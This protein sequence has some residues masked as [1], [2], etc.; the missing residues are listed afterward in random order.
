M[1]KKNNYEFHEK[2]LI[3]CSQLQIQKR[4]LIKNECKYKCI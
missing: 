1:N 4:Q 2:L 3:V